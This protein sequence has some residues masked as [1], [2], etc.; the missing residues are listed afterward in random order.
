MLHFGLQLLQVAGGRTCR[1]AGISAFSEH[2]F[3]GLVLL[4]ELGLELLVFDHEVVALLSDLGHFCGSSTW[5][6]HDHFV[7]LEVLDFSH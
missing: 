1:A 3:H 2:V 4:S 6:A 7:A 5:S